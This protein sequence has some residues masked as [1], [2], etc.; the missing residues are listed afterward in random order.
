MKRIRLNEASLTDKSYVKSIF[1]SLSD[2]E[3]KGWLK[4]LKECLDENPKLKSNVNFYKYLTG[5]GSV[6]LTVGILIGAP[7]AM[8]L[9]AA[10]IL[11]EVL[12][13][14]TWKELKKCVRKKMGKTDNNDK[15][16]SSTGDTKIN[17]TKM[18][19]TIRLTES[20][21]IELVQRII[22]EEEEMVGNGFTIAGLYKKTT[23]TAPLPKRLVISSIVGKIKVDGVDKTVGS[24]NTTSKIE[25]FGNCEIHFK[26]VQGLGE[27]SIT[28]K[29]GKPELS[30]TY[31]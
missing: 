6:I 8:V 10:P 17:E 31:E 22:K 3:K 12:D 2:E 23:Y 13:G 4:A 15:E 20:E 1:N 21:L 26:D 5:Y 24:I 27:V 18:K 7:A 16:I 11:V 25:C 28:V 19:K 29:N 30:V 14:Y 9:G